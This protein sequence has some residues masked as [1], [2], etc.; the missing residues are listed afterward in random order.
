[1]VY[2]TLR[3]SSHEVGFLVCRSSDNTPR[4]C[5]LSEFFLFWTSF[6]AFSTQKS[7][8]KIQNMKY[9]IHNTVTYTSIFVP[10]P[11]HN[12][13]D[14]NIMLNT[15]IPTWDSNPQPSDQC[16]TQ[17]PGKPGHRSNQLSHRCTPQKRVIRDTAALRADK[18][19]SWI[20]RVMRGV[21][22]IHNNKYHLLDLDVTF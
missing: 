20:T 22:T 17:A 19:H 10:T 16:G 21:V 5:Y 8:D 15:S 18:A 12:W 13:I 3:L 4:D 7:K 14:I 11:L 9:T 6:I 2:C 1:M